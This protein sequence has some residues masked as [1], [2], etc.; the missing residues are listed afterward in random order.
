VTHLK[1]ENAFKC[2]NTA[3]FITT[4]DHNSPRHSLLYFE[5]L[6]LHCVGSCYTFSETILVGSR[7][8]W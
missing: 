8:K 2:R 3:A 6:L 4:D 1:Q 7:T 5:P